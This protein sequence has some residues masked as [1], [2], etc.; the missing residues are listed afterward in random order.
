MGVESVQVAISSKDHE[1]N[2]GFLE[3]SELKLISIPE[4]LRNKISE[5]VT[6]PDK[7]YEK[8]QFYYVNVGSNSSAKMR[9]EKI[10]SELL[11]E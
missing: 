11:T 9:F 2:Y 7:I 6:H 1:D 10:I 4:Q 3:K 8:A 5:P